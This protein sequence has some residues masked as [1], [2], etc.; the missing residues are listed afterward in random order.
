LEFE[1]VE[2]LAKSELGDCWRMA[3]FPQFG[4]NVSYG[5]FWERDLNYFMKFLGN[6]YKLCQ[7]KSFGFFYK[8]HHKFLLHALKKLNDQKIFK[9]QNLKRDVISV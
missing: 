2:S 4:E 6:F 7:V 9:F 3:R 8:F 5:N 1:F